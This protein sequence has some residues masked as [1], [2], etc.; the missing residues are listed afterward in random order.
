M[1]T[2]I[3]NNSVFRDFLKKQKLTGLNFIDWYRQLRIVL[4]VEDK[5]NYLEQPIPPALVALE[6]QQE[7]RQSVSSYVLKMKS[8][9]DNLERLGHP[10]TLGLGGASS[11]GI[12]TI[13]LYTFPNRSW[14][15]DTGCGTH[16]CNTTQGLKGSRKLKPGALSLYV[17][18]GQRAAIEAIGSYHFSLPIGLVIVLNNCHYAPSI[19]RGIVSVSRLYDDG[20]VNR[21]VDKSIQ[22]SR[23][24]MVYFNVVPRDCI[25]E[26]D[27]SDSYTNVSSMYALSNKR[28]KSNLDSALLRHCRLGQVSKKRIEKLQHD[29]ILNSTDLR[30]FKKMCSL[31]VWKD[32]KKTLLTS[33]VGSKW[34]FKKKTDMDGAVHTYKARLVSKGYTQTPG[35]DYEE[36]FS[37]VANIR[38]IMILITIAAFYDY[39]IWQ[40]DVKT[41]FLN[42]YLS[43]EVYM[44]QPEG[45]VNPKYLNRRASGLCIN[46]SKS[47]LM[48]IAVNDDYVQQATNRLGCGILNTLFLYLGSRVGGNMSRICAWD[49]IVDKLLYAEK[50]R[51]S[52]LYVLEDNKPIDVASKIDQENLLNSFRRFPRS[53]VEQSQMEDLLVLL[54]RVVLGSAQ[55]RWRW[56]LKGSDVKGHLVGLSG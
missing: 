46:V 27:L 19:T 35:I 38:A 49:D 41:A 51:Y 44:D 15:Y 31:Y 47:K 6:G 22:V 5:L 36:T 20:Y 14:V 16:I 43:K 24:N 30:A 33:T 4:S 8:Y 56:S 52:R 1:T 10:V 2:S 29:G 55:D 26:I 11:S 21:F 28:S 42:G 50:D 48:G 32:G 34:L 3:V 40:M 54:E 25:F 12:F 53:G 23:N 13:E 39:E 7:E 9:I 37:P 45:F 17:G 18:N